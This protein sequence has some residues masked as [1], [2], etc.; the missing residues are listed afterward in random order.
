ML[1]DADVEARPDLAMIQHLQNTKHLPPTRTLIEGI[2]AIPPGAVFSLDVGGQIRRRHRL[3]M[4]PLDVAPTMTLDEATTAVRGALLQAIESRIQGRD[5]IGIALSGGVDSMGLASACR[6]TRA[7]LEIHTFTAGAGPED[8]EIRRARYVA[9]RIGAQ[10][11]DVIVGPDHL[12][13]WMPSLVWHLESPIARSETAQFLQVGRAAAQHVDCV[14]TGAAADGLFAGMPRHRILWLMNKVPPARTALGEFFA[15]TQ[16][17]RPP[18]SLGGRVLDRL[19]F[20]GRVPPVPG[21]HGAEN[22]VTLPDFGRYGPEF[23][24]SFMYHG[25]QNSL[26]GWLP[27]IERTFAASG[28]RHLSPFLDREVIALAFTI[29]SVHKIRRSEQKLVLRRALRSILPNELLNAPKFPMR[30]S[31]EGVFAD[32]MHDLASR[33]LSKDRVEARGFFD[34]ADVGRMMNACATASFEGVMRLWTAVLT[35]I[36]AEIFLDSRGRRPAGG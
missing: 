20:R 8:P 18:A 32:A 35:E 13:E 29:P 9:E 4:P 33:V 31:H 7:D 3:E 6:Q 12:A 2:E 25:L 15:L 24:N 21:I 10:H 16:S 11:H 30:M 14:L 22:K 5:K 34:H 23:V 27:K 19:Y 17:G 36:W 26:A 28:I 1:F